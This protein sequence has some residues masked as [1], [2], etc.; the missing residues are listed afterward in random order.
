MDKQQL[1][2]ILNNRIEGLEKIIQRLELLDN[3]D[4]NPIIKR[5]YNER[6]SYSQMLRRLLLT[7]PVLGGRR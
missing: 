1:I 5:L 3:P 2:D 4:L 6:E 7:E